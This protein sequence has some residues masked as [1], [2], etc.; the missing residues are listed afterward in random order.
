MK[1]YTTQQLQVINDTEGNMLVSASAGTGKTTVMVERLCGLLRS[2]KVDVSEIAVITFTNLAAAEMKRRLTELLSQY[3]DEPIV[4]QQLEKIDMCAISTVHRLCVD[5]LRNYFYV[6]DIDPAFTILDDLTV[7]TLSNN[8]LTEV[9]RRHN[10]AGEDESDI[11]EAFEKL[12]QTFLRNRKED[13][14]RSQITRLYAFRQ[15]LPDFRSWY[16]DTR[17]NFVDFDGNNKVLDTINSDIIEGFNYYRALWSEC[18]QRLETAGMHAYVTEVCQINMD[19]L[20]INKDNS[21]ADTVEVLRTAA[22]SICGNIAKNKKQAKCDNVDIE[23]WQSLRDDIDELVDN[24]KKFVNQYYQ[25]LCTDTLQNIFGKTQDTVQLTDKLVELVE[26]YAE[27]FGQYK[28]NRGGLD[29]SDLEHYTLAVLNNAQALQQLRDKYKL[30]FV[31]EYQD[32]NGVQEA[33]VNL[34][35]GNDNLFVVGDVKQSIYGFRGCNPVLFADKQAQY[36]AD[37]SGKVVLLNDNFRSNVDIL[38]F[39]NIICN[40]C[41]TERFGKVDYQSTAQ[42]R[43]SSTQTARFAPVNICLVPKTTTS[44]AVADK[45]YDITELTQERD[46]NIDRQCDAVVQYVK[47]MVGSAIKVKDKAMRISYGDVAILTRSM[48]DK[49][50]VLYNK[51][52]EANIPVAASFNMQGI[53][54]KEVRDIINLLRIVDNPYNDVPFVGVCLSHFGGMNEQQLA[55]VQFTRQ[56]DE[57]YFVKTCMRY[58]QQNSDDI[59]HKLQHVF[60]LVEDL[61]FFAYG[62]AVDGVILR[63]LQ[64]TRYHLYVQGLPN[65]HLRIRKLYSFINQLRD[66]RYQQ[67]IDK[68]LQYIDESGNISSEEGLSRTNAVTL[69]TMHAAKGLE[70]PV[71]IV[72][73]VDSKFVFDNFSASTNVN[74]GIATKYYDFENRTVSDTIGKFAVDMLNKQK[75]REEELRLL[76]V[77]LTRP[78]HHLVIVAEYSDKYFDGTLTKVN[79][80]YALKHSDYIMSSLCAALGGA[81]QEGDNGNGITV[82]V[83]NAEQ[84]EDKTEGDIH[85]LMCEQRQDLDNILQQINFRYKYLNEAQ[86]PSKVV[87]SALDRLVLQQGDTSDDLPVHTLV[88]DDRPKIGTAYHKVYENV[89]FGA[90]KQGVLTVIENLVDSGDVERRIADMLDIDLI[91]STLSNKQ[92]LKLVSKGKVYHEIPF[93]LN[94]SAHQVLNSDIEDSITLQ[95]VIDMLVINGNQATVVDFKYTSNSTNIAKRYARQLDSYRLAVKNICNIDNVECYVLSIADN[96]LIKVY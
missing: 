11:D 76:Y 57:Q 93:M 55:T 37:N 7:N 61:R 23:V 8:A 35:S 21:F 85:G 67:S 69:M 5:I 38:N 3:R 60:E 91:L 15:S 22:Q 14:L 31:D 86:L 81:L 2:G 32:T 56:E 58:A 4:A 75:A 46:S 41:M 20:S 33:I 45:M 62:S 16:M 10:K 78:K 6:V 66:K 94:V 54:N 44:R 51:L 77:A 59:A 40:R 9:L 89:D 82:S 70:Y 80:Q 96:K 18:A 24:T 88:D 25:L 36:L 65:G 73:F 74:I 64:L 42:L 1:Q 68:F 49:A 17:R 48:Q 12:Y 79:A 30:V 72:P 50:L 52:I 13:A 87:S 92:L 29:F 71:V 95:G 28:R 63:I 90:D 43:G 84:P 27:V 53:A 83:Y 26:E 19:A 39:V 34:L 47:Q